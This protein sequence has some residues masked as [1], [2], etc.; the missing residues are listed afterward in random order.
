M[1]DAYFATRLAHDTRR[2]QLWGY[3]TRYLQRFVP[4]N[5]AVMELG[6][7]YCYFINSV[8][9]ARRV[10]VDASAEIERWKG[11]G[12]EAIC[13]DAL[14]YLRKAESQQ[15]D[16]IL[17]SNFFEH[18]EWPALQ[19]MIGLIFRVLRPSGRLAVIQPNFRLA[20]GHYFDDYTHRAIFTDASLNDWLQS[21]G[22]EVL[23]LVPRFLPFSV[24]SRMG[25]LSFLVPLYLRL[26]YRP[27]AG[28]MFALAERPL[29]GS[30]R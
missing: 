3:L 7:G 25:G 20:A 21:G 17:A 4:P 2:E 5:A 6:A 16:F 15:F 24:K 14:Q 19:E 1:T 9:G 13:A 11:A 23:K 12:V 10:A 8:S 27:F 22:F 29:T 30:S 18:F 26:P 28:Q